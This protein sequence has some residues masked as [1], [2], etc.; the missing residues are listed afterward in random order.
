MEA[1]GG[2]T[3]S[4]YSGGENC[5][6]VAVRGAV[7][8]LRDSKVVDSPVLALHPAAWAGLVGCAGARAVTAIR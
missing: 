4:S 8:G 7:V 6:E 5:V 3:T 2:W 1:R